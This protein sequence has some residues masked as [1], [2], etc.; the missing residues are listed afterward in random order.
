[1][2]KTYLDQLVEYPAKVLK[3]ISEDKYCLGFLVNKKFNEVN[4]DD[5][6]VALE[7]YLHD[8]QY[9]NETTQETVAYVWVEAEVNAVQNKQF[10]GVRLYVTVACHKNYMELD[11]KTFRGIS[12]NRRDNIVRYVDK[13]LNNSSDFGIGNLSLMS[14]K[15][16]SPLGGFV[17]R[18]LTYAIPDF[19]IVE[20][21]EE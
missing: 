4:E 20:I 18:E 1:M 17:I 5:S 2:A 12:G 13:L 11:S 16:L 10:K 7:K 14:L 19:N 6:D 15:T 3:R 8:Y 9:V 21:D